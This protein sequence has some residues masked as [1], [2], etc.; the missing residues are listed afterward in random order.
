VRSLLAA[1]ASA[2]RRPR[3]DSPVPYVGRGSDNRLSAVWS[4]PSGQEAQLR[5]M[6]TV[7]T[8]F[9]IVNRTSTSTAAVEWGLWRTAASGKKED[10]TPVTRHAALDL[11]N[12]PNQFFSREELFETSQQH[13]DLT[14]EGWWVVARAGGTK[15]LPL[16]IWPVRPDRM[17][18]VPDREKFIRGYV[19]TSPDSEHIPLERDQVIFT[20]MPNPL[21]P[22]RGMGPVQSILTDLDTDTAQKE[23]NRTFF[24]NSA[25]PGGI[26]EVEK[27]LQDDEFAEM[28]ARWQEQHRGV[29]NAH[30]VAVIE[31]GKWIDRNIS[32]RDM[33][34]IEGM[35]VTTDAILRAFGMPKFA[36][37]M[38]DD[39][40]R[41]T[42][43]ASDRWFDKHFTVPRCE[44]FRGAL[45]RRL[46]PMYGPSAA[47]LEFDYVNPVA[48]DWEAENAARD[49][50]VNAAVS[51]IA[52]GFDKAE[53]LAAF[54]LPDI[55]VGSSVGADGGGGEG[56]MS[57]REL[58]DMVQSIYLGVDRCITWDEARDI[59][60][61]AGAGLGAVPQP[62]S[63]Q[64][65][66]PSGR[67]PL[68]LAGRP[69]NAQPDLDPAELP[70]V[71]PLQDDWE[72]AL[73]VLLAVWADLG[74][75]QKSG[76]VDAIRRIARSGSLA[77]L[78]GLTVDVDATAAELSAAM[79]DIAEKAAARLVA[80]AAAQGVDLGPVVPGGMPDVARVVADQL[81][82]GL[83]LSATSAAM[84]ANGPD[85]TPDGVADAVADALDALTDAEPA[86]QLGAALTGAQNAAR[87]ET[88]R[89]SKTV[90]AIYAVEINDASRCAPCAEIDGKWLGN[91]DELDRALK[92]YPGGAYGGYVGCLGRER[93]RGTLAGVWR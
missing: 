43:D 6:G 12:T 80:E 63:R 73:A 69:R 34:F 92:F 78:A 85:A 62:E 65:V 39:V 26:I 22:Y 13:L 11:L 90:G 2:V 88:L 74:D 33:Q 58:A 28:T 8:L 49:S 52:A 84:R 38:L 66:I 36:V 9:A 42:A 60:N 5:A 79:E 57:P 37:G 82:T 76:L 70:D 93:C 21:D 71:Q 32:Q 15:G 35:G 19:Y 14:G 27:R 20:R 56:T 87:V 72:A 61:R 77:D 47:E 48:E 59:L 25:E 50:K 45:N 31:Q 89:G 1:A 24:R 4:T 53:V 81:G 64:P 23:W 3:N 44:R 30:R 10:R 67:Q 7:G 86:R 51:L 83:R 29:A 46:L 16:E 40:N 68:A 54:D 17:T 75:D 55:A 18:P 41:A 91:T